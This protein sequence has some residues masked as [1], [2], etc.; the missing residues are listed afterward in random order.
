MEHSLKIHNPETASMNDGK[1]DLNI[2]ER[3]RQVL[4]TS[5]G[6]DIPPQEFAASRRLDEFLGLDSI[7]ALEIVVALEKEFDFQFDPGF[8]TLANLGDL[9]RLI[10][11]LRSRA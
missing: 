11:Y 2:R 9:S 7:A 1:T 3:I 6:I 8:L 5:L 4:T 10:D